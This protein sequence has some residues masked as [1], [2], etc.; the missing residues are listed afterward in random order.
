MAKLQLRV[1]G[2]VRELTGSRVALTVLGGEDY[3]VQTSAQGGE[4]TTT[5]TDQNGNST[6]TV[7]TGK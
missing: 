5:T 1:D 4:T 6:T 2:K 3:E 7:T